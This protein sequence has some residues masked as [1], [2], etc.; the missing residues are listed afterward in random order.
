MQRRLSKCITRVEDTL[1]LINKLKDLVI[2][3]DNLSDTTKA[4]YEKISL[5]KGVL[6]LLNFDDSKVFS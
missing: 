6:L 1:K 3:W 5:V 2:N 4:S